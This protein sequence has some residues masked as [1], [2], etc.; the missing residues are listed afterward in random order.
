M[1][2]SDNEHSITIT[3]KLSGK[4]ELKA[5]SGRELDFAKQKPEGERVTVKL[6]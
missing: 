2:S 5:P 6:I 1:L 4:V 3:K